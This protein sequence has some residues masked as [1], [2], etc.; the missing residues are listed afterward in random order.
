MR[1]WFQHRINAKSKRWWCPE[2]S[3][4]GITQQR[5]LLIHMTSSD[6]SRKQP[7]SSKFDWFSLE[8]L[9]WIGVY[10]V[11][12]GYS[13]G[14]IWRERK[15]E[16]IKVEEKINYSTSAWPLCSQILHYTIIRFE[17]NTIFSNYVDIIIMLIRVWYDSKT[18]QILIIIFI[19]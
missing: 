1:L 9:H 8:P 3:K 7:L 13:W 17:N 2:D 18:I 14:G 5:I 11:V 15:N 12:L 16:F 6:L 19:L 4:H 10:F